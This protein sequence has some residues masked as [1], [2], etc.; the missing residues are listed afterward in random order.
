M[1][2]T[3]VGNL[4]RQSSHRARQLYRPGFFF[5]PCL[6]FC[7]FFLSIS[8]FSQIHLEKLQ[9]GLVF[10]WTG[11]EK[12]PKCL[13]VTKTGS[14]LS[15]TVN[16]EWMLECVQFHHNWTQHFLFKRRAKSSAEDFSL[17]PTGAG[18]GVKNH[19][20][21]TCSGRCAIPSHWKKSNLLSRMFV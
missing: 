10:S 18:H 1:W 6:F 19:R 2:S 4:N 21:P 7:F 11:A 9:S 3:H 17:L 8:G 5:P 15:E 12:R 20:S 16:N 13:V 14:M